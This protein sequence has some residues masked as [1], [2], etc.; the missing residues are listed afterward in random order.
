MDR[1]KSFLDYAKAIGIF[2]ICIGHFFPEGSM[3]RIYLY[4]F[5]VPVFFV[6]A[7]FLCKYEKNLKEVF[8]SLTK[9]I[10]LP[11]VIFFMI[12]YILT[13]LKDKQSINLIFEILYYNG[14]ISLFNSALWFFPAYFIVTIT[15]KISYDFLKEK[16]WWILLPSFI[17]AVLFDYYGVQNCILGINKCCV[18]LI[19]YTIGFILKKFYSKNERYITNNK[20]A[21][22]C[23]IVF[24]ISSIT[25]TIVNK[26]NNISINMNDYNNIVY[27]II[28]ATIESVAF[29]G[30]FCNMK[31]FKVVELISKNTLFIMSTHLF[32]RMLMRQIVLDTSIIYIISGF[33]ICIIYTI[34]LEILNRLIN[35]KQ[36]KYLN[37]LGLYSNN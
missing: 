7:G 22:I 6:I 14:K 27:F 2:L 15:F 35:N 3:V 20:T 11:Y 23:L 25:Y 29:I 30:M 4:S 17:M 36:Y 28:S 33:V 19:F 10:V 26:N 5:H 24:L 12:T 21:L 9:R 8:K 37:L 1:R 18:L 13:V 32:F 16:V 34:A 31:P